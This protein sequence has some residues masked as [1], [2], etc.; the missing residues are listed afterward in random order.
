MSDFANDDN[1]SAIS[2]PD[3][4]L[5]IILWLASV[6]AGGWANSFIYSFIQTIASL[7]VTTIQKRS[8]HSMDT[9]PE[10]HAEAPQATA[11]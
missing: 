1:K 3:M 8:Q 5:V 6:F 11:S 10:F 7:Q 2:A 4:E 9:V